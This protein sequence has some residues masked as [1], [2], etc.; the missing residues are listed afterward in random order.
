MDLPEVSICGDDPALE[1]FLADDGGEGVGRHVRVGRHQPRVP[2]TLKG[3]FTG[4]PHFYI[5]LSAFI[6][7]SSYPNIRYLEKLLD[8]Y[9]SKSVSG[10]TKRTCLEAQLSTPLPQ[11]S[12]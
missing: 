5:G 9:P 12:R 10:T 7:I 6:Q 2:G 4:Y 8:G 1:E 11:V 3:I